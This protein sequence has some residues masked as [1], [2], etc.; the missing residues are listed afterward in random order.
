MNKLR[1]A[2][3]ALRDEGY[4]YSFIHEKLGVPTSTLSNWFCG[5]PYVPNEYTVARTKAGPLRS[6]EARKQKSRTEAKEQVDQGVKEV[7]SLSKR[8]IWMLGLGMYIGEGAKTTDYIRIS[9]SD[10]AVIRASIKWLKTLF[11]ISN[12]NFALR[13]H[14][15]PDNDVDECIQFWLDTTGLSMSN[16]RKSYIDARTDKSKITRKSSHGT[17]H[18]S[19]IAAGD[20]ELGKRLYRRLSGWTTGALG[21]M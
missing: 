21:Q 5:K 1:F 13:L 20:P 12:K 9:N 8:D 3:E 15:Y 10:P 7:G 17:A 18:L 14:L 11:P 2:A 19:V 16:V 4:S 6:A